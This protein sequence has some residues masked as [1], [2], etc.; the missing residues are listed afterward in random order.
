MSNH[1][2]T[3]YMLTVENNYKNVVE[4]GVGEGYLGQ[5]TFAFLCAVERTN[6]HVFSMD[7]GPCDFTVQEVKRIGLDERWTFLLGDDRGDNFVDVLH[8]NEPVEYVAEP[9]DLLFIDTSHT[10]AQTMAELKKYEPRVKTGGMIILHD[11]NS[12][13]PVAIAVDEYFADR[14]DI[15]V[16]EWYNDDGLVVIKKLT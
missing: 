12:F 14:E 6:G 9:I 5:S 7:I 2:P 10:Y 11:I 15:T 8:D 4:L 3:L 1:V 16:Y 13:P